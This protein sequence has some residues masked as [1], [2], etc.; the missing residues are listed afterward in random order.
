MITQDRNCNFRGGEFEE[1][2]K[3]S[4]I[5]QLPKGAAAYEDGF[6][7]YTIPVY[8]EHITKIFP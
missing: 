4:Q 6:G 3:V 5:S 7:I 8:N 2:T 1:I